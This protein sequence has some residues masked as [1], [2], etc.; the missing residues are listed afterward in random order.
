M[1]PIDDH[2]GGKA[3]FGAGIAD[4]LFDFWDEDSYLVALLLDGVVAQLVEHHNGIVG[5][6][7]S[8]PLGSTILLKNTAQNTFQS[9][10]WACHAPPQRHKSGDHRVGARALLCP[11]EEDIY[12]C[13]KSHGGGR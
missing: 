13:T 6:R 2:G 12:G 9:G 3:D 11:G 10:T 1:A 4:L 7:G 8:N 5:V